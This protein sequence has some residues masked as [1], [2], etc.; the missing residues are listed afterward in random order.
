MNGVRPRA[1]LCNDCSVLPDEGKSLRG[2]TVH[3]ERPWRLQTLFGRIELR[4]NYHHHARSGT[5][6]RPL[7]DS[8]GLAGNRFSSWPRPD[9]HWAA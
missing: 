2:E 8:L 5:G 1:A 6:R 9:R 4:R 3:R 7:E